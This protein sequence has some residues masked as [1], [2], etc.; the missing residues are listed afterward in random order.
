MSRMCAGLPTSNERATA[1]P[2]LLKERIT[3]TK[4]F[5]A[6]VVDHTAAIQTETRSGYILIVTCMASRAMYLD[7][8]PSLEAEEFVLALRRFSATQ[9]ARA[10]W[11]GGFF[12]RL[13]RVTKRTLQIALGKKYLPDA[14]VLTLVKEAESVVNNR[15]LM[16]SGDE[17][18]DDVLNPSHLLRG[19]QV[20]LMAPILP[21]DH[22][23]ATFTSRRLRDRYL[24]LTDY[25]KAFRERWRREY[26]SALRA[27]HDS[28]SGEPSKLHPGDVVLVKQEN[29]KRATW[30]LGRVVETYPDDDGIVQIALSEDDDGEDDGDDGDD[31]EKGA[32]SSTAGMPG[33]IE[34]SG[35]N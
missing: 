17:H 26:L 24:K 5:T 32:Y 7:F 1:A 31:G 4:P 33:I 22:L 2:P 3:L 18:E 27:Q 13:I 23:N 20:H 30:P 6:V 21:D 25:L 28:Q 29:Q 14:H 15:P 34:M 8:C 19:H 35:D 12:E 11:E 10:P 9:D 16:Y